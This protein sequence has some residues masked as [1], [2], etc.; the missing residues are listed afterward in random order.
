MAPAPTSARAD[1]LASVKGGDIWRSAPDGTRAQ[2]L[3][4]GGDFASPSQAD[5]E[6]I[7]AIDQR[8]GE[9]CRRQIVRF[10]PSGEVLARLDVLGTSGPGMSALGPGTR[11]CRRTVSG[12]RS[13]SR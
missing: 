8:S 4:S 9:S 13:A 2:S 12:L 7:F 10:S 5:D 3:T 6:T 11:R 1:S